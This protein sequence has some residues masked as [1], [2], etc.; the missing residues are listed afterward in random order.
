MSQ[1][2][3]IGTSH[4]AQESV[5][6]IKSTIERTK[7]QVVAVELDQMRLYG[8]IN[9]QKSKISLRDIRTIGFKGYLFALLGSYVQKKLGKLVGLAPGS[10]MLT[11]VKIAQKNNIPFALID[12]IIEITLRRFSQ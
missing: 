6:K 8:L 3:I 4:I 10:D 5:N 12:R 7:P 11:A 9:N 1:F 2:I